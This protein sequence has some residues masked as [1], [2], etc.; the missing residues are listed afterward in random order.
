MNVELSNNAADTHQLV[1]ML[2]AVK[3]NV[4]EL[5]RQGLADASYRSED[6][7]DRLAGLPC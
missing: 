5:P 6:N 3:T 4:G 7:F 2:Q 1:P